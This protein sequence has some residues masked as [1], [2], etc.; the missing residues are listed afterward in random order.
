[1]NTN[2]GFDYHGREKKKG[3]IRAT[4]KELRNRKAVQNTNFRRRVSTMKKRNLALVMAGMMTA[5]SLAGC[6]GGASSDAKPEGN[7]KTEAAGTEAESG[8]K[9]LT[10]AWW[11]NQVRNKRTQAALDKYAELNP[12]VT[13]DGQFSEWGDYWNKLATS[14]AGNSLPD[15]IQMDYAYLDQY[16]KNNL[17]LDLTPYVENGTLKLDDANQDVLNSGKVNDKLYAVPIGINAPSLFY[18]KTVTDAAGVTIKDNMTLDEFV[19]ICKAIKEKTGYRTNMAYGVNQE[20][21]QYMVRANG[22]SMYGEGKLNLESAEELVP[23]FKILED[24]VK[25]GW[26]V[27]PSIY[28]EITPGAIEQDPFIY[29]ASKDSRSWCVFTWSNQTGTYENNMPEDMKEMGVTTWPSADPKKS[30]FLKPAQFFSVSASSANPEEAVKLI[31]YWTNSMDA[32]SILLA[33][34]GV[35]LSEKVAAEL[36]PSLDEATQDSIKFINEVVSPSSSQIDPPMPNGSS[37]VTELLLQ[38]EE[39]VAYGQMTSEE[40]AEEFFV[41]G[42]EIMASK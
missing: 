3:I 9:N 42:N 27:E 26:H 12:G 20:I 37:E 40:A 31:D 14:S 13:L 36:S 35:P 41:K 24:G 17:L 4:V 8:E 5:A 16:A 18:N 38:L 39:K 21:I 1:M 11:G 2:V 15:V 7:A 23:M 34:R 30:N 6:S 29:G 33:E 10:V 32:N 22:H 25:E 19:E 28:A